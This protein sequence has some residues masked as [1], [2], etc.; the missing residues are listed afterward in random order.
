[1]TAAAGT[2]KVAA[3][4]AAAPF[5]DLDAG[6]RQVCDLIAE[7][8][9]AGAQLV[10]FPETYLPG[11][12]AWVWSHPP[13]QAMA[14]FGALYA[15]AVQLPGPASD[16]IAAAAGAAGIWVVLG[17]DEKAGGTLYNTL[18]YYSPNGNLVAA[19]RKLQPTCA[20]RTVYGRGD[21]R[22]VFVVD[23]G[24]A[25][26]GG[27]ICSE[28]TIDLQTYALATLGEQLHVAAWPANDALPAYPDPDGFNDYAVTLSRGY[29][30]RNQCFVVYTQGRVSAEMAD[31]LALPH[32]P[33]PRV[34]GGLAGFIGPDGSWCGPPDRGDQ[35]LVYAE[36][37]LSRIALAKYVHDTVG[38][39]ARP[40]VFTFG[41]R[42]DGRD[43]LTTQRVAAVPSVFTPLA[44]PTGGD[45][46]AHPETILAAQPGSEHGF[47]H[48]SEHGFQHG[49]Q[50]S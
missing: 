28:H 31:H 42:R 38:H 17:V 48:G 9:A 14:L 12:P 2:V 45:A 4:H 5:L 44:E 22:D 18:A 11:Y 47:Q 23:T 43:A 37:E 25:R 8:G 36:L 3:V 7:A 13:G 26:V 27:M 15:N 46:F 34:G 10:A 19:H 20:E 50:H 29:A 41:V 24:F 33:R 21:G 40:D 6:V 35:P 49:F 1:M 32:G 16:A 39:Y 30:I